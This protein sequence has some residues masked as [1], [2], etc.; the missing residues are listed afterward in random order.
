MDLLK[1]HKYNKEVAHKNEYE[2]IPFLVKD[3]KAP[4]VVICPGGGYNMI[5]SFSFC[6]FISIKQKMFYDYSIREV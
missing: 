4:F 5:A 1:W 6:V 2:L 3:E